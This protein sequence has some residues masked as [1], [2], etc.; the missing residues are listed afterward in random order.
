MKYAFGRD[1]AWSDMKKIE[2]E[3]TDISKLGLSLVSLIW[4][5]LSRS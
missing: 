5:H 4:G 2:N 3:I 1:F